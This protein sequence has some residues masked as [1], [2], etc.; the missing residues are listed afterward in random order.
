M[1][2]HEWFDQF[3]LLWSMY[4][5]RSILLFLCRNTDEWL[6]VFRFLRCD[7]CEVKF[8]K[9]QCHNCAMAAVGVSGYLIKTLYNFFLPSLEHDSGTNSHH[10]PLNA[11]H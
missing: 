5:L 2:D 10:L 7:S 11:I 6:L 8:W 1:L 9:A 3:K 4:R